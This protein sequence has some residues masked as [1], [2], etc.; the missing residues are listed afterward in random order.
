MH[1][2]QYLIVYY[3]KNTEYFWYQATFSS[4]QRK[5]N[6]LVK[7]ICMFSRKINLGAKTKFKKKSVDFTKFFFSSWVCIKI[8]YW[9]WI[10]IFSRGKKPIPSR[11]GKHRFHENFN[12]MIIFIS[13]S[14]IWR[15]F[16]SSTSRK[17][18]NYLLNLTFKYLIQFDC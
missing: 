8:R 1:I 10:L 4:N 16:W 3:I 2:H 5:S 7:L 17:C 11:T 18:T 12:Y 13:N 6:F 15:N 9:K 14:T